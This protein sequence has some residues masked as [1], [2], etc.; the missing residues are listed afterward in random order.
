MFVHS[1]N[2]IVLFFLLYSKV[3]VFI[4]SFCIKSQPVFVLVLFLEF[5]AQFGSISNYAAMSEPY[6][7]NTSIFFA[8]VRV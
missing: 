2:F 1:S 8:S 5:A 3:W 4:W 6:S 7:S